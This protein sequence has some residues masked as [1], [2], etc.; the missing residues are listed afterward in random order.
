[1]RS[2]RGGGSGDSSSAGTEGDGD[3]PPSSG[4]GRKERRGP[5]RGVFARQPRPLRD[6]PAG[7]L[8]TPGKR[9]NTM[10]L[11]PGDYGDNRI[12]RNQIMED[13]NNYIDPEKERMRE[14]Y[15]RDKKIREENLKRWMKN[16]EPKDWKIEIDDRG[17]SF[18]RGGRKR[19]QASVWI[20]PGM[21]EVVVNRQPFTEY[22]LREHDRE[23][24]LEPFVITDTCGLFDIQ[25]SVKGG[26]LSGQAGAIRLGVSRA[27]NAYDPDRYRPAL[28]FKGMLTRDSRKVERKKV[29]K[30]KA[31]K[32]PQWVRR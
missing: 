1:V 31:R 21:G 8:A 11:L 29:G 9:P 6:M 30:V 10:I 23:I 18:G 28:K 32:S 2:P 19:A 13:V 27:L 5:N 14:E 4:G 17:R 7:L 24:C 15:K 16:A 25:C 26:G 3:G 22:F 20:Q 12:E